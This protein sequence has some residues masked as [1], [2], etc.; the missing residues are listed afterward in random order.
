MSTPDSIT[1]REKQVV[2]YLCLG[3]ENKEIAIVLGIS[4]RTV[5]DHRWNILKKY[6]VRNIVELVRAVYGIGEMAG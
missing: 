4:P 5:E 3:W 6:K 2:E 1:A